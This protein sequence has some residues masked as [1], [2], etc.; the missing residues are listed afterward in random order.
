MSRVAN[1]ETRPS[2]WQS[3]KQ[4]RARLPFPTAPVIL[5]SYYALEQT[6][7]TLCRLPPLSMHTK[8]NQTSVA[9]WANE[10]RNYRLPL[11]PRQQAA[12]AQNYSDSFL[13]NH[14]ATSQHTTRICIFCRVPIC[15]PW[16][17]LSALIA[18]MARRIFEQ[19]LIRR[20]QHRTGH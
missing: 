4:R 15:L 1:R 19:I 14:W 10:K 7:E 18:H 16:L 8:I 6:A 13:I 9:G 11:V 5:M 12:A 20:E 2:D 17:R 3:R